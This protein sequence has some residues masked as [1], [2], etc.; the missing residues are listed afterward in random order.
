MPAGNYVC[1]RCNQRGHF[2]Q[3]CPTKQLEAAAQYLA[4]QG[5]GADAETLQAIVEA[6]A[7]AKLDAARK[8]AEDMLEAHR[9]RP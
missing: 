3:D 5:Q 4:T 2:I 6:Q 7:K 8:A 1:H 9:A